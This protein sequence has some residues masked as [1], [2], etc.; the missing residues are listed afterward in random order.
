MFKF[1][2]PGHTCFDGKPLGFVCKDCI[3][4]SSRGSAGVLV[5]LG[6]LGICVNPTAQRARKEGLCRVTPESVEYEGN[7]TDKVMY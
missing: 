3:Y 5:K 1:P 4:S 6:D 2:D 7:L